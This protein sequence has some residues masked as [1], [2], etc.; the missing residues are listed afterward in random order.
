MPNMMNSAPARSAVSGACE[1]VSGNDAAAVA[2]WG[3]VTA[4]GVA[5]AIATGGVVSLVL[6]AGL[7][8]ATGTSA[9]G[10]GAD[11]TEAVRAF[12]GAFAGGA[13]FVTGFA[14]SALLV[15]GAT[16]TP[17]RS[18]PGVLLWLAPVAIDDA[19]KAAQIRA[20][21]KIA[22]RTRRMLRRRERARSRASC[23][24][25]EYAVFM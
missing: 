2:W 16:I 14:T 8:V 12:A 18:A 24:V 4:A 11:L 25:G 21:A 6:A 23:R 19:A 20:P 9:A 22:M 17:M 1:P 10:A 15:A 3:V 13:A 7:V 5:A